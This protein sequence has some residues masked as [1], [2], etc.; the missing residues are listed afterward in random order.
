MRKKGTFDERKTPNYTY[1]YPYGKGGFLEENKHVSFWDNYKN[2][3][4]NPFSEGFDTAHRTSR[5]EFVFGV[6][7]WD[8]FLIYF[9]PLHSRGFFQGVMHVIS[10]T[11]III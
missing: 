5:W 7:N 4:Y 11:L 10:S 6:S 3:I 9:F 8:N 2:P 1:I